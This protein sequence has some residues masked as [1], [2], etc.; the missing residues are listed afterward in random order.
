MEAKPP[1]YEGMKVAVEVW[2]DDLVTQVL[3]RG[4]E[5]KVLA[6]RGEAQQA[7]ALATEAV[8]LSRETDFLHLQAEA[9]VDLA[10]SLSIADRRDEAAQRLNEAIGLYEAKGNTPS[11]DR[12]AAMRAELFALRP[13]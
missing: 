12:A 4:T 11:R 13:A 10:E 5:A 3:W 6:R 8:R 2:N 9:L 1:L 7:E